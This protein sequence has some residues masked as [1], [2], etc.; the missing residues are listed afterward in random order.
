MNSNE[1]LTFIKQEVQNTDKH[2]NEYVNSGKIAFHKN[3]WLW[4]NAAFIDNK[5][6]T[7]MDDYGNIKIGDKEYVRAKVR[8]RRKIPK[9]YPNTKSIREVITSLCN[10]INISWHGAIEPFLAFGF[11]LIAPFYDAFWAYE[12]MGA[13]GFIG[14]T[15]CEI[16]FTN[17]GKFFSINATY[18]GQHEVVI[19]PFSFHS[20]A[21]L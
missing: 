5:L 11:S 17:S 19:K 14:E 20:N 3:D 18:D 12:G 21:S 4:E 8:A 16:C 13:L 7:E 2:I 1:I 15:E 6:Y 9:Y 10:N